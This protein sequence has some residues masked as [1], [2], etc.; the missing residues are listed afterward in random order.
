MTPEPIAIVAAP[1]PVAEVTEQ[2]SDVR[3]IM[4]TLREHARLS[5]T[6]HQEI[7]DGVAECQLRIDQ[8]QASCAQILGISQAENP[9][10]TQILSQVSEARGELS[11]LT[12]EAITPLLPSNPSLPQV[13][14]EQIVQD[15]PRESPAVL[16]PPPKRRRMYIRV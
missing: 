4:E 13:E 15:G 7:L 16:A 8:I 2:L 5:E 1:P 12:A 6:R 11:R 14:P 9:Q 3:E 10:I